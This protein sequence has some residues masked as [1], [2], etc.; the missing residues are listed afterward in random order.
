MEKVLNVSN[1]AP[2]VYF[3][4]AMK[5]LDAHGILKIAGLGQAIVTAAKLSIMCEKKGYP[6][7]DLRLETTEVPGRKLDPAD[8]MALQH[9]KFIATGENRTVPRLVLTHVLR[10]P[11][12]PELVKVEP[13]S[14]G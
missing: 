2:K 11:S 9:R 12:V 6:R 3:E 7:T 5:I 14:T 8:P 4:S 13:L 10:P 1:K